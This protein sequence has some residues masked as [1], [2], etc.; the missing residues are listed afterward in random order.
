MRWSSALVPVC[1]ALSFGH[2]AR[3]APVDGEVYVTCL[4]HSG[5]GMAG[6]TM[7]SKTVHA[8]TG[9][10][11]VTCP[12]QSGAAGG[13]VASGSVSNLL[14]QAVA[15]ATKQ[16]TDL[17]YGG[18]EALSESILYD[19]LILKV[20]GA[21]ARRL[22]NIPVQMTY[23]GVGVDLNDNTLALV[24]GESNAVYPFCNYTGF[25]CLVDGGAAAATL[26]APIGVGVNDGVVLTSSNPTSTPQ[27]ASGV[28]TIQGPTATLPVFFVVATDNN[29]NSWQISSLL[30]TAS[31]SL[32]LPAGVTCT[33]RSGVALN[34]ACPH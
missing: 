20:A 6:Q 2:A 34:G 1:L 21:G 5:P 27:T 10:A 30:I 26:P 11:T 18:N 14:G 19:V 17:E 15:R 12:N 22:T 29:S 32:T 16:P 4:N 24:V 23:T 3:A 28:L 8:P 25:G 31:Y 9:G 7:K 13:S 33:S